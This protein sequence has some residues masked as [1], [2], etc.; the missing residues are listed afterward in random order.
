MEYSVQ[1]LSKSKIEIAIDIN[2]DDWN[3]AIKEAYNKTKHQYSIEGFRKGKV[4]MNVLIKRYGVEIFYEDALD[5]ALSKH[6]NS[7]IEKD[8]LEV[9]GRPDVDVKE[10]SQEGVK[11][12]ITTAVKPSFTLGQYKGLEI[13]KTKVRVT[14]AEVEEV[15]NK[16][17]ESRS[18]LVEKEEVAEVAMG[19]IITL[20][21]SGSID[22]IK[23]DGGT[24]QD[25][26]LEIGSNTFIPGFESQLVGLK[27]GESKDINVTFP[28]EYT[29]E[30]AGKDAVFAVTIK[31]IKSKEMPTLDDEFVKDISETLNTVEEWKKE[32]KE[33]IR[34]D[35]KKQAEAELEN[36]I[37]ETIV[38]NTEIDIPECMVEEELDYRIQELE[39]SMQS[40]GL[41]FDDYL[42][43]TNTTVEKI[44][45]EKREEALKNIKYRLVMEEIMKAENINV[46]PE[47]LNAE[48]N[49]LPDE[50]KNAQQMSY[51]ANQM[52]VDRLFDFL[53]SN[54]EII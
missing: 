22:G 38:N 25:Q 41:K 13:K 7:I 10:V 19:D 23:F 49:K 28:K 35:K 30:L 40:Y 33:K 16:E 39:R 21:Y 46:T 11:A 8:N 48:V 1:E 15:I 6:Y 43:Y 50:Q 32:I 12:V 42:K 14:Q 20:D 44:K 24:A 53:K 18:R 37:M 2:K 27:A 17:L 26:M 31:T 3:E 45:E 29:E 54:N 36:T 4:P 34:E 51:I 9:I 52:I 5:I 47:E